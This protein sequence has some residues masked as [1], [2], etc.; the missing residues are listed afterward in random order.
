MMEGNS[1]DAGL[2]LP[3]PNPVALQTSLVFLRSQ[4]SW[5]QLAPFVANPMSAA[6]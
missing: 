6:Q 3:L 4:G 5:K 1:H 2:L